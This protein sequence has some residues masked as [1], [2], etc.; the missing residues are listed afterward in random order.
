MSIHMKLT[1]KGQELAAKIKAGKGTVPLDITRV[2]TV[3]GRNA[4]PL[5]LENLDN[6]RQTAVIT[7]RRALGTRAAITVLLTN[8]ANPATGEAALTE[9]YELSQVG[10]WAIDPDEGEIL[11]RISQYERP[12]YVPAATEMGWTWNPTW[13]FSTENASE[14]IVNVDPAG[15]L[16]ARALEEHNVSETAHEN[17][18]AAMVSR[19]MINMPRGVAGLDED[20]LIAPELLPGGSTRGGA[21]IE[22]SASEIPAPGTALHYKIKSAIQWPP[23]RFIQR[24][25]DPPIGSG[26]L[27]DMDIGEGFYIDVNGTPTMFIKIH[28]GVPSAD[29]VGFEGSVTV[30]AWLLIGSPRQWTNRY[31]N[32]YASSTIHQWINNASSGFLSNLDADI[33]NLIPEIRIPYIWWRVS[34][35]FG[36]HLR[37]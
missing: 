4:E 7:D 19:D 36:S 22:L 11:Y 1:L 24:P 37:P 12:N 17:R 21:N 30:M 3:S 34:V 9:G 33:R 18:F 32:D 13:N 10:M 23:P 26:N 8:Q 28:N 29:Y 16:T 27:G 6:I 35:S 5:S 14:V 25:P 31:E 15:I 2:A 20:G